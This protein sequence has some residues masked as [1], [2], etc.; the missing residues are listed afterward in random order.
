VVLS[1]AELRIAKVA[2][3]A[4]CFYTHSGA[5]RVMW[6]DDITPGQSHEQAENAFLGDIDTI[7]SAVLDASGVDD[8]I[9]L[10]SFDLEFDPSRSDEDESEDYYQ[11]RTLARW[12]P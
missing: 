6:E 2:G 4:S 9:S 3:G 11:A 7:M 5:L 1:I 10:E 12:A 8:A